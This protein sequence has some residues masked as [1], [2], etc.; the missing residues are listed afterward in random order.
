M[1]RRKQRERSRFVAPSLF[2][3][4]APVQSV[5]SCSRVR[6]NAGTMLTPHS[7]ECGYGLFEMA[8]RLV[9]VFSV[10]SCSI[11]VRLVPRE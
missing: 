7:G 3:L 11:G 6:Q 4:R 8:A 10:G 5:C 9:S 2:S 1:N